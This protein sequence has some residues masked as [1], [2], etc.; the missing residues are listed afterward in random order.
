M[1]AYEGSRIPL[2]D[3]PAG[4]QHLEL[5]RHRRHLHRRG[6]TAASW[7]LALA[8]SS[9]SPPSSIRQR[10]KT[11]AGPEGDHVAR[12]AKLLGFVLLLAAVFALAHLT[13]AHLGPL[14]TGHAQVTGPGSGGMTMNMGLR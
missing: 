8:W 6:T 13:G 7:A 12:E 3:P 5:V 2:H 9:A 14:T 4:A 10:G 11:R 1:R